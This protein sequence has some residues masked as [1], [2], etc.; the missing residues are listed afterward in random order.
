MAWLWLWLKGSFR[1]G[2]FAA[3]LLAFLCYTDGPMTAGDYTSLSSNL[4]YFLK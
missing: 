1:G 3:S 2:S 4:M